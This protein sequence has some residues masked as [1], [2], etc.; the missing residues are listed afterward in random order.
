[1]WQVKILRVFD[2]QFVF[3]NFRHCWGELKIYGAREEG[4]AVR[5]VEVVIKEPFE[6]NMILLKRNEIHVN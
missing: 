1:M 3:V 6:A 2:L 5:G 4:F